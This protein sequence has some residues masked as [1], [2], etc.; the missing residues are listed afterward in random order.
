MEKSARVL[1]LGT[2]AFAAGILLSMAIVLNMPDDPHVQQAAAA[3]TTVSATAAPSTTCSPPNFF[4]ITVPVAYL[5]APWSLPLLSAV[6]AQDAPIV[7]AQNL[8]PGVE[9]RDEKTTLAAGGTVLH[10]WYLTGAPSQVGSF[11]MT[12]VAQNSCGGASTVITLPVNNATNALGQLCPQGT[13]GVYPNCTAVAATST[14]SS[15]GAPVTTTEQ[16]Q[17]TSPVPPQQMCL[18]VQSTLRQG[19]RG[20]DVTTLQ[21]FLIQKGLLPADSATGY[22]GPLT[23]AAV[24]QFQTSAGVVSSGTE[25]TT[26]FGLVGA[27]TRAAIVAGC[28]QSS[29]V[30]VPSPSSSVPA[31]AGTVYNPAVV[32][33]TSLPQCPGVIAPACPGGTL[34]SLGTDENHCIRGYMCSTTSNAFCSSIPTPSCS[35]NGQAVPTSYDSNGCAN[36]YACQRLVCPSVRQPT[37]A[38]GQHIVTAPDPVTGCASISYCVGTPDGSSNTTTNTTTGSTSTNNYVLP[39]GSFDYNAL[40]QYI[41]S[42]YPGI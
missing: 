6:E 11:A 20:S 19:S 21:Q 22:F 16:Q 34:I 17:T 36:A 26:G 24:Q 5:N 9:L 40:L 3:S 12:I 1:A 13:V 30:L 28:G 38:A 35:N 8:A 14:S 29:S 18:Q 2:F 4:S 42:L 7:T 37:C 33:L 25:D 10:T 41:N 31:S 39:D 27:R 15:S 32:P 23:R